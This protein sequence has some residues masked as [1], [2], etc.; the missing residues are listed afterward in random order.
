[1]KNGFKRCPYEHALYTKEDKK[2]NTLIVSLY[3]NDLIFTSNNDELC[4]EFKKSMKKEFEMTDTGLLHY[5]LGIEVKQG[6]DGITIS[7][8]K[9]AKDLL[10]KFKMSEALPC[11]TPMEAGLKLSKDD[12]G[13]DFDATIYKSLVG[14]LMYST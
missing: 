3:V 13:R 8:K 5:F 9:Y 10:L 1:M 6:E 14:S 11:S 12:K 7:Q 4:E 2:G